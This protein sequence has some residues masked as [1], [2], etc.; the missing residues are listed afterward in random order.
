MPQPCR[1]D[2]CRRYSKLEGL[3]LY[4]ARDMMAARLNAKEKKRAAAAA[5]AHVPRLAPAQPTTTTT[6]AASPAQTHTPPQRRW[7]AISKVRYHHTGWI[8]C[9]VP[10]CHSEAKRHFAFCPA[11]ESSVVCIHERTKQY[12][13]PQSAQQQSQQQPHMQPQNPRDAAPVDRVSS[14]HHVTMLP[15]GTGDPKLK[16]MEMVPRRPRLASGI[17]A[18]EL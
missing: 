4:H 14:V 6:P 2:T 11:H 18:I 7:V 1:Q 8:K 12:L 5:V 9:L 10:T 13:T 15:H 3:C 16:Q 17:D